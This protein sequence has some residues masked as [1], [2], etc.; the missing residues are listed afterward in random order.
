MLCFLP[1][2]L[3]ARM[4]VNNPDQDLNP[5]L[6]VSNEALSS[7]FTIG[8]KSGRQG[9]SESLIPLAGEPP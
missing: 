1:A 2:E 9:I 3:T 6:L 8:A 7:V 4:A 5:K